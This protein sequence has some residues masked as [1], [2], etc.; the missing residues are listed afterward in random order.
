MGFSSRKTEYLQGMAHAIATG[1]IGEAALEAA[2]R[3]KATRDLMT[4]RGIGRWSAE[5]I[6]LRGLGRL[7]VFPGD[8]VGARNKLT[9][10]MDLDH[11]PSYDEI[12]ALLSPWDP[13][14]GMLYFHLLLDGIAERGQLSRRHDA[15][16]E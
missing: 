5:Y 2:D 8:D 12:S 13:Y 6:L 11:P 15:P 3:T 4:I 7:D 10:F 16:D 1:A 9:R 14:A